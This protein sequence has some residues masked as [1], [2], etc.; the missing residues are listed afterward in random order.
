ML[1]AA[2]ALC[3]SIVFLIKY[4]DSP[5]INHLQ[6]VSVTLKNDVNYTFHS[7]NNSA[8]ASKSRPENEENG[9]EKEE[10]YKI[11]IN[12]ATADELSSLSG[13]GIKKAQ[14]IVEYRN[15][16]GFFRSIEE[17]TEVE[18]IGETLFNENAD[19]ITV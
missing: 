9:S 19:R 17:L 16:N 18:G 12:T 13:I 7:Q 14:A 10:N 3:L 2:F 5:K 1:C 8:S 4:L 6:P 11:N 15:N